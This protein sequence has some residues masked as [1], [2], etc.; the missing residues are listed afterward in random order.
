MVLWFKVH[1]NFVFSMKK[2]ERNEQIRKPKPCLE[3]FFQSFK[4]CVATGEK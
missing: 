3:M 1:S 4:G 2:N